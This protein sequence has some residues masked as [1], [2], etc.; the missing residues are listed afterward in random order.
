MKTSALNMPLSSNAAPQAANVTQSSLPHRMNLHVGSV[1]L[2]GFGQDVG[3]R[4]QQ[5][6]KKAMMQ[7][8]QQRPELS[9]AQG[10][11][12]DRIS[13]P[14]LTAGATVEDAA[15]QVASGLLRTLEARANKSGT[16]RR[17]ESAN[18]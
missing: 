18:G 4:F 11:Q 14:P 9:F 10:L 6:L 7:G 13:I 2:R 16:K 3:P 15:R 12:L 1:S 5:A 8:L 17:E